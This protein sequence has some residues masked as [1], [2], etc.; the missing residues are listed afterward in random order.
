MSNP[1]HYFRFRW[2]FPAHGGAAVDVGVTDGW[3]SCRENCL[4]EPQTTC[5][6]STT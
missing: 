3:F 5:P 2:V 1:R 6:A 4:M